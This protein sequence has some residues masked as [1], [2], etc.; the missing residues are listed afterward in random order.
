MHVNT[1]RNGGH[2]TNE[3]HS[4]LRS[5]DSRKLGFA[6]T[7][8]GFYKGM[9]NFSSAFNSIDIADVDESILKSR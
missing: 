8:Q 4:P 3:Q 2:V 6:R 1:I 9:K 5:V 7:E